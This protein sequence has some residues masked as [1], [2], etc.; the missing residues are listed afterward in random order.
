MRWRR[1]WD[2]CRSPGEL[3]MPASTVHAVLT[4]CR[5][6]RLVSHRPG[7]RGT[8]PPLR[9]RPSRVDD[10]RRRDQVRQH[11]RRRRTQV[12]DPTAE[13][14]ATPRLHRSNAPANAV[15]HY[16]PRIG[17]AFLHT[18][19]DDHSRIAYAEICADEKAVTA[20]GVLQRAV[21]WF[22]DRGVIVERVLS[23]NGSA[24]KSY[25]WRDA[26]AELGI[27]PETHPPL[28]AADQREDRTIPPHPRR[29]LGLRPL[30]RLR[31]RTTRRPARLAALPSP[32]RCRS[33]GQ[34]RC[35]G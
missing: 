17:T 3:G 8:D 35:A 10:P 11:P 25:A 28:P 26:C 22:A 29:R 1:G 12:P 21:A 15:T 9:T 19:I 30:L 2:R 23:D 5:I 32:I 18:V 13:Q 27:T 14:G 33:S 34:R 6:N 4:R 7:H 16:R 31:N 24:Y 20:I